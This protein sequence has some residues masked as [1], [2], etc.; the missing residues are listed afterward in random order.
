MKVS[1]KKSKTIFVVLCVVCVLL[2]IV[3]SGLFVS[4]YYLGKINRVDGEVETLNPEDEYFDSDGGEDTVDYT[5]L[6]LAS[7]DPLADDGLLNIL[8]VGQDKRPGEYG[9][10][11]SDTM[12]LISANLET[13]QISVISFLRDLYVQ[14]PGYSSNRMNAAYVWGGYDLLSSVFLKNFGIHLDGYFEVDFSNFIK[15]IDAVGGVDVSLS[16]AEARIVGGGATEGSNHL[17]GTQALEYARIRKL[18]SDFGRTNRQRTVVLS[19]FNKVKTLGIS[20]ILKL[21]DTVLPMITTNISNREIT[22]YAIKLL[23]AANDAV[24]NTYSVPASGTYRDET[25]RGM[26]VLVPDL[27][28]IND[29]LKNEYLPF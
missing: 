27:A 18:D 3:F 19:L 17:N 16:A 6:Q 7:V 11:R 26:M 10:T 14:I 20:D 9:R 15:V 1:K 28:K 23:P 24:V 12:L 13:K 5:N 25:I 21:I 2:L 8:L 29:L 4:N 22:S